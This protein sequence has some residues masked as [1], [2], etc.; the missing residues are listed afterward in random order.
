MSEMFSCNDCDQPLPAV[1]VGDWC[2]C[3]TCL[4]QRYV[5]EQILADQTIAERD[6]LRAQVAQIREALL[7]VRNQVDQWGELSTTDTAWAKVVQVLQAHH[8]EREGCDA[9]TTR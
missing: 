2:L 3:I 9:A 1:M 8:S 4:G 6:K 7:A 5:R